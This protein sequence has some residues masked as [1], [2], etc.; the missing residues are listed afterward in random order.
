MVSS[1]GVL[2]SKGPIRGRSWEAE[3]IVKLPRPLGKSYQLLF[4]MILLTV[5]QG[6]YLRIDLCPPKV[7]AGPLATQKEHNIIEYF[8]LSIV[9][10]LFLQA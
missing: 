8:K 2:S 10:K 5:I 4:L 9:V 7:P 6:I 1:V 3:E